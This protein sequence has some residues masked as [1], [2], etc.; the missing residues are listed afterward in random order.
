MAVCA[1]KIV[2]PR[3]TYL[4]VYVKLMAPCKSFVTAVGAAVAAGVSAACTMPAIV[5]K[6]TATDNIPFFILILLKKSFLTLISL[7][8]FFRHKTSL[9]LIRAL[10]EVYR[11]DGINQIKKSFFSDF[12]YGVP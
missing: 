3:H 1:P 6:I 10:S 11:L 5:S 4:L 7:Q 2:K 9:F 12:L 8:T